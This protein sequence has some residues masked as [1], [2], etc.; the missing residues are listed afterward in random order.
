MFPYPSGALHMGHVRVY[1]IADVLARF[2]QMQGYE[3]LHPMGWDSFG[4]P[5]EN[6]AIDH[7]VQPRQWTEDNIT[8][9]KRQMF[10]MGTAF[11]W[12]REISTCD[13]LYYRWTQHLFLQLLEKGL[14]YQK[15]AEVNWDPIDQTVLANEQVDATGRAE[16]SGALVEKRKLKQWFVRIT[17]YQEDLLKDL[18]GLDWPQN[19]KRLQSNWIGRT[20]G[21][22]FDVDIYDHMNSLGKTVPVFAIDWK[23]ARDAT[24]VAV[25]AGHPLLAST[26]GVDAHR[27]EQFSRTPNNV[28]INETNTRG[29]PVLASLPGYMRIY[30]LQ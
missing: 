23:S 16:R 5:A 28:P 2:K 25:G 18:E 11:D 13:P 21:I 4:L 22:E 29:I 6:A 9:M 1:T 30:L 17:A 14:I 10:D 26:S 24:Y 20:D 7:G 12:D 8:K 15:E 19:V 3:V 27:V